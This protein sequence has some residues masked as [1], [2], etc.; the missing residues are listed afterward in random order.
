[1]TVD[2]KKLLRV[3]DL[4][5]KTIEGKQTHINKLESNP[6]FGIQSLVNSVTAKFMKASVVELDC[7]TKDLKSCIKQ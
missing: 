4:L 1:M 7:I 6:G 5:E 2:Q 3:I